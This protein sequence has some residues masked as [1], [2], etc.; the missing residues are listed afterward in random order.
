MVSTVQVKA[1]STKGRGPVSP[2][3]ASGKNSSPVRIHGS[4]EGL[5]RQWVHPRFARGKTGVN[6]VV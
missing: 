3:P 5:L 1:S 6:F 4:P 2:S